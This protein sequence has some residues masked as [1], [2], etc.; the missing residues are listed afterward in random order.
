MS[1]VTPI[2]D[3]DIHQRLASPSDL[4]P[5]LP[6]HY[7]EDIKAFG[8]RMPGG[9][10]LNGGDRGYR[11][12]AWPT[13]GRMVGSDLQL[14]REQLLDVYPI[15]YGI[16][17]GQ[18]LRPTS[19]LPD[20]DYAAALAT[21]YNDWMRDHWLDQEPRLRGAIMVAHQDPEKAAAEVRR[22]AKHPSMVAVLF[23]NGARM[24]YGQRY[25][26]PI[27]RACEDLGLPLVLHTGSEGVGINPAPSPV[28]Y[29]AHYVELRQGRAMGYQTHLASMIFEGLFERFPTLNVMFVEGGY[30]WLPTYLWRLDSDWR[31]L[32]SQTPWVK[33]E[34]SE[35]V[36]ERCLFASQ[37]M[38]TS[39][40]PKRLLQIFEWAQAERT[41]V[42][43]SDYPHWDFDSPELALPPMPADLKRRVFS[44]NAREF[45]RLERREVRAPTVAGPA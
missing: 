34:P 19:S 3:C 14:M 27:Y 10:Y 45:F 28:G 6:R 20:A 8:L 18:E 30:I 36:F 21:A 23:P 12:D 31:A 24:P 16:L 11:S 43:A 44:E 17:L 37:P 35:Y 2:I 40:G 41:L 39:E 33:K 38:E 1:E 13:G 42:F 26:D 4:F 15:E 7:V 25:Y 5:Y 29:P 9:G 32:R 22:A